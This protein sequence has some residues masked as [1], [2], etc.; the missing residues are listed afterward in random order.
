M[1]ITKRESKPSSAVE[2][3]NDIPQAFEETARSIIAALENKSFSS[4]TILPV[5]EV[6][7][8]EPRNT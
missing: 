7:P 8:N 4:L 5:E 2:Q 1:G 6:L 3:I